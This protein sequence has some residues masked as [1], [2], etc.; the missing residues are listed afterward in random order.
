VSEVEE[1]NPRLTT[2]AFL[3]FH[4][5]VSVWVAIDESCVAVNLFCYSCQAMEWDVGAN[6][7]GRS[8]QS[9]LS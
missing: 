6:A 8:I 9:L 4:R 7:E 5:V 1:E 2:V 3:S